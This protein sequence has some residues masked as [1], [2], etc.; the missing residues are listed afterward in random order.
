MNFQVNNKELCVG[1]IKIAGVSI[2][3][4]VLIGDTEQIVLSSLYDTPPESL[5]VG[6]SAP[7]APEK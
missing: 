5:I 3:S 4:V 2:S 6:A 1:E 7:L